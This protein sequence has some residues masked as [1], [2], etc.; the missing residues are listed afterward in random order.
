MVT[1]LLNHFYTDFA[2]SEA[3]VVIEKGEIEQ[4]YLFATGILSEDLPKTK[5][6]VITFRAAYILEY[7]YFNHNALFKPYKEA[8]FT[9]FPNTTNNSAKRHFTHI[10]RDIL[11]KETP[12]RD[13]C[14]N[15]AEACVEWII[16]PK[17]RVAVQIGAIEILILLKKEVDW[18]E[19]SLPMILEPIT[20]NPS[21][22][23]MARLRRWRLPLPK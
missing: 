6:K 2:A 5:Q 20:R 12:Q 16:E 15:I 23:I 8:F 19:E 14:N 10:M 17:V 7:I 22:A 13:I 9:D 21:P 11:S 3:K 4:L 1:R 18:I